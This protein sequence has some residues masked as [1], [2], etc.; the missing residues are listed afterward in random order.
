MGDLQTI[1]GFVQ[2]IGYPAQNHKAGRNWG[3]VAHA[4]ELERDWGTDWVARSML[5]PTE[6]YDNVE[7]LAARRPQGGAFGLELMEAVGAPRVTITRLHARSNVKA[8]ASGER[9]PSQG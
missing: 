7:T 5:N 8:S 1:A 9:L 2:H 4:S 6:I 3:R